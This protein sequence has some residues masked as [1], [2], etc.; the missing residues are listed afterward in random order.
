MKILAIRLKN[1]ASIAGPV[2]LDFT[3][4]P[5]ASAGLFAITG[6]TGAG[7]STILDA[8]CL[9]LFGAVPRLGNV[10]ASTK[11]P[12]A[13]GEITTADPRTL[14]RR[15]TGSGFAEVDFVGIDRRRYRARWEANRARER[16]D[17]KLQASRQSLTD[18]DANQLLASQKGEYRERLEACLGLNFA[19][20]TRAVML[21]QSD[22]SAFLK[23]DDNER[24][25][26]LE[27][28]TDTALYSRLGQRAYEKAKA[29]QQAVEAL[30]SQ[31]GAVAPLGEEDRASLDQQV[32]AAASALKADQ[33][34]LRLAEQVR[35]WYAEGD[36]LAEQHQAALT[37]HT[38]TQAALSGLEGE[39]ERLHWLEQLAPQR[40]RFSQQAAARQAVAQLTEQLAEQEQALQ[41]RREAQAQLQAAH[42]LAR[43]GHEDAQA[44]RQ[45][46]ATNLRQAFDLAH[47]LAALAH[48]RKPLA[49]AVAQ[50][51]A[52]RDQG[53]AQHR[54]GLE[55]Q[56]AA[57]AALAAIAQGLE[58]SSALA[59]LADAWPVHRPRL[60]KLLEASARLRQGE[61]ELP[62]LEAAAQQAREGLEGARQALHALQQEADS[63]GEDLAERSQV[64]SRL[65]ADNRQQL[66]ETET[67]ERAWQRVADFDERLAQLAAQQQRLVEQRE[68]RTREGLAVRQQHEQ[69]TAALATTLQVLERQRLARDSSVEALRQQ[70]RP[71]E[72]CNVCGSLEHPWHHPEP[73]A[74]AMA[75]HDAGEELR[76]RQTVEQHAARLAELRAE[77][78]ALIEQLKQVR[79][80]EEPLQHQRQQCLEALQQ[81]P[82]YARL[83]ELPVAEQ[84]QRLVQRRERLA[85]QLANDEQQQQRLFQ[86]Q[87]DATRLQQQCHSAEQAAQ[88]SAQAL[89]S[90]QKSLDDDRQRLADEL[91]GFEALL[92]V[93]H[94]QAL[95]AQPTEAFMALDQQVA[96]RREQLERQREEQQARDERAQQLA[97]L[98]TQVQHS[99]KSLAEH[100]QRLA[101]VD[102]R[103]QA[104]HQQLASLLGEHASADA[105][106]TQLDLGV[107]TASQAISQLAEQLQQVGTEVVRLESEHT[108]LGHRL[109]QEA[110]NGQ[111]VDQAL[112]AWRA[113]L[114]ALDDSTLDA[115]LA[116]DEGQAQ[117]MRERLSTAQTALA[118]A[119]V[120]VSERAS[121]QQAHQALRSDAPARE[122]LE[123][124]L[125]ELAQRCEQLEREHGE[126]RARQLDDQRRQQEQQ[127][128]LI[129]MEAAQATAMRAS[130][131][132]ALI[133]SAE[134]DRFRRI[135]QAYNLDR[136]VQHAN[137]QLRQLVRR[138]RLKRGGSLLGLLVVD[139]EM[140]DET[141]SVHSLSGGETFL[142]SLALALGL[143]SM[144]SSTL[145]I[146]SLFID[147]GFG[148]L[149]PESLQLAMDALDSLQAQGRKVAVISHVQEMHERIPV[150]IRVRRQGNGLSV[151]ETP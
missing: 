132:S 26:L 90:Q 48:D 3:C 111:A 102:Q 114:P 126:L 136:L 37:Q 2:T 29:A 96:T 40:H 19:Q 38:E 53:A 106:Q 23:A 43:Q 71:G 60:Q 138:Y 135:A 72:P 41:A 82:L 70:L 112:Q 18:L 78:G 66:K 50:A 25:E 123:A 85:Q 121:R 31:A 55:R 117:E 84:G 28:L 103:L 94:R 30:R 113:S 147:E 42:D 95:L 110:S 4:E 52:E 86:W 47:G 77:V 119:Q 73:L 115:L 46:S 20:F 128:L 144:A 14:L 87:Q 98:A 107:S 32:N 118:Q 65:L 67:L 104:E 51:Q 108:S 143:A 120:L 134:G 83:A 62:G 141:R 63:N 5:L 44:A 17:G 130:R 145:K 142:V 16:A 124:Q 75:G 99:E 127:Q 149:D 79:E 61:K 21:A 22:F 81:L 69:A 97:L 12:D 15:G 33:A 6:P 125:A 89:S 45:A 58:S 93:E 88:A 122:A 9:A 74:E 13:D 148:S 146:E 131:L 64:L 39:R 133:G 35:Q 56:A 80:Q 68:A 36:Q 129:R 140:G 10:S 11:V 24:S 59:A 101:H 54:A 100:Q 116:L 76:A 91:Q 150:Q 7:K 109:A 105:W 1:L 151:V 137:V 8:L 92:P 57:D 49:D 27:K 34:S 139:T